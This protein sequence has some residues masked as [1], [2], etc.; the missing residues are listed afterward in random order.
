MQ[1]SVLLA[2]FGAS[3]GFGNHLTSVTSCYVSL[4]QR[5][6]QGDR[7]R[8]RAMEGKTETVTAQGFPEIREML[9]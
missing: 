8:R 2:G 5:D 3:G 7:S 9:V 4:S 1:D 6:K